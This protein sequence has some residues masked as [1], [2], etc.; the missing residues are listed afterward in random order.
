MPCLDF[1]SRPDR[2]CFLDKGMAGTFFVKWRE[3][4]VDYVQS[5]SK[6]TC[7]VVG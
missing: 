2:V 1:S 6:G 7:Q 3:R 5:V 4:F